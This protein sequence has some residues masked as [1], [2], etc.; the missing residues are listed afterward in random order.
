MLLT[1][2]VYS[3]RHT[4][5]FEGRSECGEPLRQQAPDRELGF[6]PTLVGEVDDQFMLAHDVDSTGA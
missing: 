1:R 4:Q 3:W 2:E 5:G 6:S